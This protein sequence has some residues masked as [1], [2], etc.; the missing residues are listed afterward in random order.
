MS[1]SLQAQTDSIGKFVRPALPV[2]PLRKD[3]I[4]YTVVSGDSYSVLSDRYNTPISVIKEASG[5]KG[6]DLKIGQKLRIPTFDKTEWAQYEQELDKYN[7]RQDS[8]LTAEIEAKKAKIKKANVDATDV[9]LNKYAN[10]GRDEYTL[11]KETDKNGQPTGNIIVTLSENEDISEIRHRLGFK[12]TELFYNAIES[13]I[14]T[15][16]PVMSEA[17]KGMTYEVLSVPK[18]TKFTMPATEFHT[19][20][21]LWQA[22]K[23]N[24]SAVWNFLFSWL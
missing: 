23:D 7:A 4:N 16:D 13:F 17:H 19:E 1:Y 5:T 11:T 3:T 9:V 24:C 8:I 10:S 18:G 15:H 20:K 21:T 12:N 22:T 14:S 2:E 6:N